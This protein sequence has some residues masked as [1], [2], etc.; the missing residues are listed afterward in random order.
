MYACGKYGASTVN[1][2]GTQSFVMK[3]DLK[4]NVESLKFIYTNIS[5]STDSY[6]IHCDING[7]NIFGHMITDSGQIV[8]VNINIPN[9]DTIQAK[10]FD[11]SSV[12]DYEVN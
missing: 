2:Y 1:T 8:Y 10:G 12:A 4:L 9:M 3:L 7:N 6:G 5:S 11:I